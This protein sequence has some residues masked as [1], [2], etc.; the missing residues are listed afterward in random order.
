MT[1][2]CGIGDWNGP[3]PGDPSNNATLS[4]VGAFGGIDVTWTF[5]TTNPA[6]VAHTLLFRATSEFFENSVQRAVVAGDNY[7]DKSE[8]GNSA[9]YTYW[10][11]IQIVSVN[12]TIGEVI[13]PVSAVAK[14][15][16]A[17]TIEMLT[18]QIT[19]GLL[20]TTLKSDISKI[21][22]LNFDL[23]AEIANRISG[24]GAINEALNAAIDTANDAITLIGNETTSRITADAATISSLDVMAVGF[25]KSLAGIVTEIELKT[26]PKSAL[27]IKVETLQA[28]VGADKAAVQTTLN[29]LVNQD[30]AFASKI[31]KVETTLNG[32]TVAGEVGLISQIDK[33]TGTVNGIWSARISTTIDGK[34][35]IGGFG[36]TN[37]GETVE[38]GFDVDTFWVGK[39]KPTTD[40][41]PFIIRNGETFI[42][43]AVIEKLT[44]NKLRSTDNSFAF[45]NGKLKANLFEVQK[46]VNG[47][48]AQSGHGW[49]AAG[50]AG[51]YLGPGGLLMG[52]YNSL[53]GQPRKYFEVTSDGNMSMPGLRVQDGVLYVDQLEVINTANIRGNAI[54][55]SDSLKGNGTP[56]TN[57][58]GSG[59]TL[60]MP[61]L[62]HGG[63]CMVIAKSVI[64]T[65]GNVNMNLTVNGG[66]LDSAFVGGGGSSIAG[67]STCAGTF[68]TAKG[69]TYN[70]L[71]T[72]TGTTGDF[73]NRLTTTSSITFIEVLR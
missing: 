69:V 8:P 29:A 62:G 14:A 9:N 25:N 10:Y 2:V 60:N 70:V 20:A 38:A 68:P 19:E 67:T 47:G 50:T 39:Q 18:G 61:I 43:D 48:F 35:L 30:T 22:T 58:S 41:L 45:E 5:P 4:A 63:T 66:Y 49:P 27:A 16:V 1:N 59:I 56:F 32:S 15:T 11:W 37:N 7:Y 17:Q 21:T 12:G 52:N 65:N 51:F 3:K 13:G 73:W 64:N 40:K 71:I 53:N 34:K 23:E 55:F 36:L 72:L 44:I 28:S 54:S 26:G 33:V 42:N 57:G 6:A 46:I 24:Q 31:D